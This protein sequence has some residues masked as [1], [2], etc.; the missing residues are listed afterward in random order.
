MQMNKYSI[1][2]NIKIVDHN[3]KV[4]D[5]LMLNNHAAYIYETPYNVSFM[6]TQC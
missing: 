6:I 1:R 5:K 4:G 2:E 3:Y